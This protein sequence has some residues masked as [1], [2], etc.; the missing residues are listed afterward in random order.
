MQNNFLN[1]FL[2]ENIYIKIIFYI[3]FIFDI[4]TSKLLKNTKKN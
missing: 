2:L 1:S 4:K 3:F